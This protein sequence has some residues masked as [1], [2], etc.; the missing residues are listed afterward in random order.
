MS[1]LI[2]PVVTLGSQT[3]STP[4]PLVLDTGSAGMV[5][6]AQDVFP[7]DMVSINGF[8]F[9]PGQNSLTFHGITVTNVQAI[10]IY[11]NGS[12][13]Y[14]GNIGYATVKF[15]GHGELTTNFM[16]VLFSYKAL[17]SNGQLLKTPEHGILGIYSDANAA[18]A[19]GAQPSDSLS[20][21]SLRSINANGCDLESVLRYLNYGA[22][23]NAGFS[24]GNATLDPNCLITATMTG[25]T[26]QST[27]TVGLSAAD[28]QAYS[29]MPLTCPPS[30]GPAVANSGV[31]ACEAKIPGF[32]ISDSGSGES[33]AA[34]VVFDSGTP[35]MVFS[36]PP[37]ATFPQSLTRGSTE[38]LT[39][40][41]SPF[42]YSY[43]VGKGLPF[44][45]T[46]TDSAQLNRTIIGI[47]FF[48]ERRMYIDFSSNREGWK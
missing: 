22:G 13:N 9:P 28:E 7:A 5:I 48:T 40:A 42:T 33:F 38:T 16:P 43:Q 18:R 6:S 30:D 1:R 23:V 35:N 26:L 32:T 11:G 19:P 45:T 21:C 14:Y 8:V 15:G 24:L 41:A 4:S 3:L 27:L 36:V 20:L 37:K 17:G 47:G 10:K 25:C 31:T 12:S 39:L 2:I 44:V 46:V 29:S 34:K